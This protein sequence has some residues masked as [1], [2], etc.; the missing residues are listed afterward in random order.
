[1]I[2]NLAI[3]SGSNRT[4]LLLALLL[5]LISAVLIGV[6][7]SSLDGDKGTSSGVV[8]KPVLVAAV[9]IPPLTRITEE[10]L[11]IK[12]IPT[13]LALAGVFTKSDEAVGQISQVQIVVGEQIMQTKITS[14]DNAQDVFGA[15]APLS[16]II[17]EGMRGFSIAASAVGAAGGLVRPGD[18][19]DVILSG[20]LQD[21]PDEVLKSITPSTACYVLQNVE[22]LALDGAVKLTAAQSD[23]G[24]IAAANAN[25]EASRATLAVTPD[26]AWQ[27]AA[28]QRGVSGGGVEQQLWISLR[29]FGD[30][31]IA[32]NLPACGVLAAPLIVPGS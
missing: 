30:T 6:Y 29:P 26:Q 19:V 14:P 28:V 21:A 24:S 16:L 5:G 3:G 22:V 25:A 11:T 32:Q 15:D 17:P 10:M 1:M 12:S 23:A 8:T 9:D 7:L 4:L 18:H 2:K 20:E 31:A 13:D 27:L